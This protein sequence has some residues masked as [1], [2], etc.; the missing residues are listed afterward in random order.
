[1][2]VCNCNGIRERDVRAAIA[3]GAT[4]PV[5]VFK[6]HDT[7]AQCARCVCEIRQMLAER[8]ESLKYAAE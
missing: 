8:R 4:K 3:A 1:M 6:A 2:Y 5:H 7:Q